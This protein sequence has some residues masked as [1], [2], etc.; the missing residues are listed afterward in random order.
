MNQAG[1]I[2][3]LDWMPKM[4]AILLSKQAADGSWPA[5]N[6]SSAKSAGL[7]FSTAIASLV[8]AIDCHYLPIYQR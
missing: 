3:W 6:D 1:G 7:P 4:R 8:L 5:E 2:Y